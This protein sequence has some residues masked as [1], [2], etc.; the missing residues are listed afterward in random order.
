LLEI[1]SKFNLA[2][3][4]ILGTTTGKIINCKTLQHMKIIEKFPSNEKGLKE[5]SVPLGLMR[6]FPRISKEDNP[7]VLTGYIA[8]HA[9]ESGVTPSLII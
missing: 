5:S 1:L 6:D 9:K 3:D 8:A 4:R 7:K 2:S